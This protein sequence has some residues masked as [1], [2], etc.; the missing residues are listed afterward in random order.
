MHI[1]LTLKV[2]GKIDLSIDEMKKTFD[3]LKIELYSYL[4][5]RLL[6]VSLVFKSIKN[7]TNNT[8]ILKTLYS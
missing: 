3:K 2:L 8:F 7:Q 6:H 1:Y 5:Y 4:Y